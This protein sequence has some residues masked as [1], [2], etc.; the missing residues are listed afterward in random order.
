MVRRLNRSHGLEQPVL[1]NVMFRPQVDWPAQYQRINR[2]EVLGTEK[3]IIVV[4][5]WLGINDHRLPPLELI[6]GFLFTINAQCVTKTEQCLEDIEA[7]LGDST[8]RITSAQASRI[9]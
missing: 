2:D 8:R 6:S 5:A 3:V 9:S 4:T 1:E 7:G